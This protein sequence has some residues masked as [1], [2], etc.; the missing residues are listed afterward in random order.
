VAESA[1]RLVLIDGDPYA[2]GALIRA[3]GGGSTD[4]VVRLESGGRA[5]GISAEARQQAIDA[6]L[7]QQERT[8]RDALLDRFA[9]AEARQ[10]EAVQGLAAVV[11]AVRRSQVEVVLLHDDPTSTARLWS[12]PEPLQIGTDRASLAAMGVTDPQRMRADAVLARA[13]FASGAD[14]A[15]L[16]DGDADLV[17]GIGAL[18]RWSDRSTPHDSAPA[19]PGHGQVPGVGGSHAPGAAGEAE[20]AAD[21]RQS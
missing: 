2:V 8:D 7:A 11:D 16:E 13:V 20:P 12:G 6:A 5:A 18:L 1:A 4:K 17:D 14:I 10:Q 15:L 9:S 21:T 3:L 19:M